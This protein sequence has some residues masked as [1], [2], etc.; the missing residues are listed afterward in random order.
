MKLQKTQLRSQEPGVSAGNRWRC[1]LIFLFFCSLFPVPYS[2]LHA[3]A[4]ALTTVKDT[5][6]KSDG[7][8]AS[9]TIVISW[10]EFLDSANKAVFGGSKTIPLT[11]GAL[12]TSL[13]PNAGGSP[14]GTSYR[15]QYFEAAGRFAEER[16]VVPTSSPLANPAQPVSV[17][18]AGTPGTT[19]YYYWC[20]ATNASGETLLSPA[21]VTTTSHATL[22]GTN[23][24]IIVCATVSGATGYKAYRTTTSTAPS[25]TGL[26]L[27]GSSATTTIND[28]SNTLT[29]ATIPAVNDTDPKTVSQ[30]RVLGVPSP[31]VVIGP[32]QVSGTAVV[33]TPSGTQ[34]ITAANSGVPLQVKGKAG[35]TSNVFEVYDNQATPQLQFWIEDAGEACAKRFVA[36]V[37]DARCFPGAD[38]GAKIVAARD[39]LPSTGG[40]VDA[41]GLL[42][43]QAITTA[44]NVPNNVSLRLSNGATYTFSASGQITLNS[45]SS[46]RCDVFGI[47]AD[48][49]FGCLF[50]VN[51]AGLTP[52]VV[53]NGA[54]GTVI[55]NIGFDG[56]ARANTLGSAIRFAS[57]ASQTNRVY[58]RNIGVTNW[59]GIGIEMNDTQ[60]SHFSNITMSD[61]GDVTSQA[62]CISLKTDS[63]SNHFDNMQIDSHYYAGIL[64]TSTGG[65][66]TFS[67][68]KL[69]SNSAAAGAINFWIY[70]TSTRNQISNFTFRVDL[71]GAGTGDCIKIDGAATNNQFS[72]GFCWRGE[73]AA[74]TGLNANN[75]SITGLKLSNVHF[76][77]LATG[78]RDIASASG[79]NSYFN[80]SFTSVTTPTNLTASQ[81]VLS[82]DDFDLAAGNVMTWGTD[83]NLYRSA[84]N[85]LKTDGAFIASGA[86]TIGGGTAISKHLSATASLDFTALAANT[87]EVLTITVTGATDGNMVTLGV[88]NALADVDGAT[89][90][91]TFFGWVSG[92]DTV[93]VRRCNVTG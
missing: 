56:T 46:L 8:L 24:N 80:I 27:V 5:V 57:G 70:S 49:S 53:V 52:V 2:L 86:L 71:N 76:Q 88:P 69:D 32:S 62:P 65:A 87:C 20:T 44:V 35:N 26:Y 82:R 54:V 28:Q 55:E 29:S 64:D 59:K 50:K 13:V 51:T 21:R 25:G 30:V 91:T 34:T 36:L 3:Q 14:S 93:S 7:S 23:Y 11:S 43:S 22:D 63:N 67:N 9:G 16:W 4:P 37:R 6:Y 38:A 39:D 58:L 45:G 68:L 47:P 85:T 17:T 19:M 40:M 78:I 41:G 81:H 10:D 92:T 61:C 83:T 60:D 84:A 12:A 15:V 42:G 75:A 89:E 77:G 1:E 48:P 90:R 73:A 33:Q 72:N 74:G 79:V 66:N 31:A 18:Q